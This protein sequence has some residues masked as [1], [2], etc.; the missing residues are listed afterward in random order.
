MQGITILDRNADRNTL[1]F[2][3]IDIIRAIGPSADD[4]MWTVQ[5]VECYGKSAE[6]MH[7]VADAGREIT[8]IELRNLATQIDQVVDGEFRARKS[9]EDSEWLII[10][11]VD[12]SGYDVYSSDTKTLKGVQGHFT[13]VVAIPT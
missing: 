7:S 11:A 4:S 12:S 6:R 8:G 10:R 1:S 2:D 3:L 13:R 5:N 9:N